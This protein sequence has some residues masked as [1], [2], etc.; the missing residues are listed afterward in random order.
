MTA[1]GLTIVVSNHDMG[2]KKELI[3]TFE[4][5]QTKR[6]LQRQGPQKA[7]HMQLA[8][9]TFSGNFL[10]YAMKNKALCEHMNNEYEIKCWITVH[11]TNI[12]HPV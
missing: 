1:F 6:G 2:E 3:L 4:N 8:V 11:C 5:K 7:L 9:F 10:S 12:F